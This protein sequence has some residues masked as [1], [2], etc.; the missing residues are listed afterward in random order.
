VLGELDLISG[1]SMHILEVTTEVS[2]L[3]KCFLAVGALKWALSSVFSE[4]V[5]QI[6]AL[7]KGATAAVILALEVQLDSLSVRVLDLDGLVPGLWNS[8]KCFVLHPC[9]VTYFF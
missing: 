1:N 9:R 2:T 5:P 8:F 7:L 6:A 4:V 3:C